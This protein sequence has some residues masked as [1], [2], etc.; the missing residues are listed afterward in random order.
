MKLKRLLFCF[1]LL[2]SLFVYQPVAWAAFQDVPDD[3]WS[4]EAIDF[5]T[6]KQIISGYSTE[7]FGPE[8][9]LTR[10]QT[11]KIVLGA[12]GKKIE[13]VTTSSFPDVAGDNSLLKYIEAARTLAVVGGYE[14]GTFRPDQ[15]V[16]RAEFT[17]ILL[18]AA[19]KTNNDLKTAPAEGAFSD[20]KTDDWFFK[21]VYSAK[22]LGYIG[23]YEDGTF[24]PNQPVTRAEAAKIVHKFLTQIPGNNP[25]EQALFILVNQSRTANSKA[26]LVLDTTLSEIARSHSLDLYNTNKYT[27]KAKYQED[28]PNMPVPWTSHR[29]SDGST[30]EERFAKLAEL[31]GVQYQLASE[32]IGYS[33]YNL[34]DATEQITRIHE[35]MMAS[36]NNHAKNILGDY[37][38]VG[39]GVLVS[40]DPKEIYLTEVFIK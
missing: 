23:G 31:Y 22:D 15:A 2:L 26:E 6:A 8:D 18:Q 25:Y 32:N 13:V 20:V 39:I 29:G 14:D 27:D 7:T 40:T 38:K 3:Y 21:Y 28:H 4:K 36:V 16:T 12:T 35:A 17:K 34:T 11:V 33:S 37:T 10:A 30:F 19:Y 24:R 1:C 5:L 9:K